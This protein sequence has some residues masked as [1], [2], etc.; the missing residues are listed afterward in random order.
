MRLRIAHLLSIALLILVQTTTADAGTKIKDLCRVKGQESNTL[1]G[2][3]LVV[4]LNGTGDGGTYLP[5]MRSL[6]TAMA[7]MGNRLG[8]KAGLGELK[9]GKNVALVVV[10]ATVPPGGAR[11]GDQIDCSV[12]SI[13]S[14]KSLAGGELFMTP[15]QGPMVDSDRVFAFAQGSI[16]NDDP[17]ALTRGRVHRGCRL[18]EDLTAAF[19]KDNRVTLILDEHHADF[20]LAQE[21]A[22]LINSQFSIE[23]A[24]GS[25]AAALDTTNIVVKIPKQYESEPVAFVSQVLSLAV[26]DP[27]AE[28]R[29]VVNEAAG[30][31]VIGADVEIGPAVI[32]HKNIVIETGG[33]GPS[34]RFV[35]L[36]SVRA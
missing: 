32:S 27:P 18:E 33:D 10:T 23:S 28:A 3:G 30:S 9:D 19:T 31:I 7:L 35:P 11:Q 6:A 8:G 24:D 25:L 17:K 14:A 21:I 16:H 2:L 4:G 5:T 20:E 26:T 12:S 1:R 29:V 34:N 13:G 22:E 15:M 36:D